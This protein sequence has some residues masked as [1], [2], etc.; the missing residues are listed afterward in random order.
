MEILIA[1][2]KKP[3]VKQFFVFV[4]LGIGIYLLRHLATLLLL[5]FIFIYVF[6]SAEKVINRLLNKL[7]RVNR[8]VITALLYIVFVGLLV[9]IIRVYVPVLITQIT[10]LI[11]NISD[12]LLKV[13]DLPPDNL[14][15][16]ILVYISTNVDLSKYV[17]DSGKTILNF[18]TNIGTTSLYVFLA[19]V[20]SLFFMIEKKKIATFIGRFKESKLYWMYDDVR[21]FIKKFTNSFGKVIQNQIL[22]SLINAVL[23]IILLLILGFPDIGGLGAMIFLLGLVPV[24]GVFISLIPLS[25]IAFST[26]GVTYVFYIL[27]LIAVLHT[28]ES[29]VLNPKL[30]SRATR[31]PVFFT[32]LVLLISEHFFGIWGL[33]V[34]LPLTMF[35]LDV[36]D[37]IP[38]E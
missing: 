30:M 13:K 24:A 9:L 17:G 27:I 36:L 28:L 4:L 1:F 21:Y 33:I 26:G 10:A 32:L 22:I 18:L 16:R 20:L 35:L 14:Y 34:G 11:G 7:F 15:S 3:I 23:S 29:Y 12:Y 6:N 38:G 25:I 19:L 37:V 5:T 8:L 31:M 2:L